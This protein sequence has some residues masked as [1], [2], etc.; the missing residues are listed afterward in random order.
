V[1]GK[2]ELLPRAL[3]L[4]GRDESREVPYDGVAAVRVGRS[5]SDRINGGPAVVVERRSGDPI[6]IATVA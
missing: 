3:H 4:E 6:T 2:L 1:T 5:A